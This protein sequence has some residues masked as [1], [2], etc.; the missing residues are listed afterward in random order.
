MN[1]C[2]EML[3]TDL[4]GSAHI[5]DLPKGHVGAHLCGVRI[6]KWG[7]GGNR[8]GLTSRCNYVWPQRRKIMVYEILR[9]GTYF[10]GPPEDDTG[11]PWVLAI[12][13]GRGMEVI[14]LPDEGFALH[15]T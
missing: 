9:S 15:Y 12:K 8:I 6:S 5:C 10:A 3:N 14:A 4:I 1:P 2:G 7:K 13:T 11:H